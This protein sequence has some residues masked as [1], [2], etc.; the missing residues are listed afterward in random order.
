VT[1]G[2][3]CEQCNKSGYRGRLGIYELFTMNEDFRHFIS[4]SYKETELVEMAR[5]GG[6]HTLMEDGLEKVRLGLTTL[7]ELLRVIGPQLVYQRLCHSCD[8][9]VDAKFPFCP[10]CGSLRRN[11]CKSCKVQLEQEWLNCP[12]CGT[13]KDG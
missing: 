11:F 1:R 9:V 8:R 6:M 4:T 12:H 2:K 7:E 5:A 3:G 10:F 13:T